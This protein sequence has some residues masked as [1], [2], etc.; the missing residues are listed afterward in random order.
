M[1]TVNGDRYMVPTVMHRPGKERLQIRSYH[2][3]D[4]VECR[5]IFSE[6]MQQLIN[7]VTHLVFSQL[8]RYIAMVTIFAVV[9]SLKWSAWIFIISVFVSLILLA[10]TYVLIYVECWKF[11]NYC[12]KTDLLDID[13]TYMSNNGCHMW[14]AEWNGKIV[15]M[16]GL[17]QNENHKPGTA[18]LQRMS[19][20]KTCRKMGVASKLLDELLKYAREQRLEKIVL[21][22]TNAQGPAIRLYKKYGFKLVAVLPI[23]LKILKDLA[24]MSFDLQL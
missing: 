21:K 5:E 11:I 15:G 22:T 17:V 14:V 16:V 23:Q 1:A 3:S 19:V 18:E 10:L 24:Y 4:Y 9:A 6:G 13:K 20:S 2:S 7:L 8:L 12:L